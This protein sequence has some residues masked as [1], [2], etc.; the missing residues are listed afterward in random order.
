MRK[1]TREGCFL[2]QMPSNKDMSS[3]SRP[4]KREGKW[5]MKRGENRARHELFLS[6]LKRKLASQG[7]LC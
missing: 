3:L 6:V 7:L 5:P 2:F 1:T 4:K